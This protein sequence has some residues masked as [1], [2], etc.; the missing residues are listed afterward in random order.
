MLKDQRDLLHA[1][2]AHKVEYLVVGGHA[3]IAY[4]SARFTGDIDVWIR[5]SK[6]NSIAVFSAL[7]DFGAPLEGLRPEDFNSKPTDYFQFGVIPV[8]VDIL[9]GIEGVDFDD[10]WPRRVEMTIEDGL[11]APYLSFEDL[12]HNKKTVGRPKDLA[13]IHDLESMRKLKK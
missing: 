11:T 1:L 9:Q 8:R 10:A 7:A 4:G 5:R 13:D 12:L 2:N 3:A 6:A